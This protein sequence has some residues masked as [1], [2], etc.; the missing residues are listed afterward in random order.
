METV[1]EEI[2]SVDLIKYKVQKKAPQLRGF[3]YSKKFEDLHVTPSG[4]F[5]SHV[6]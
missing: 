6:S 5:P 4:T 3:F 1:M 2:A